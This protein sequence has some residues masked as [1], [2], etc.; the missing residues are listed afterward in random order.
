[1]I[2]YNK[3]DRQGEVG[4]EIVSLFYDRFNIDD[5]RSI[6]SLAGH[7]Q[8][9]LPKDSDSIVDEIVKTVKD[10]NQD[11]YIYYTK[12]GDWSNECDMWEFI[13]RLED[14]G[15]FDAA[16]ARQNKEDE[17]YLG[18]WEKEER[19]RQIS[20]IASKIADMALNGASNEEL[21]AEIKRS[22]GYIDGYDY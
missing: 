3:I 17:E 12:C 15:T 1:M 16:R 19:N 8:Y 7:L 4:R 9:D 20:E 2:D 13:V 22:M 6:W 11:A 5:V 21:E 18:E 14:E 10:K